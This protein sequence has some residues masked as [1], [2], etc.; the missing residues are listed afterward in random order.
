MPW[1]LLLG[2][3][4]AIEPEPDLLTDFLP[5]QDQRG[6]QLGMG[7]FCFRHTDS[8]PGPGAEISPLIGGPS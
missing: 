3:P 6:A 2:I 8:V 1:S 5:S 7:S 4:R